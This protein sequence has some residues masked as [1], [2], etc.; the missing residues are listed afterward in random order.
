MV[1]E[2]PGHLEQPGLA[3]GPAVRHRG[4]DQVAGAVQLVAV[5]QMRVP[6]TAG[7]LDPGVE[8]AVRLLGLGQQRGDVTRER[9]HARLGRP[10]H[11]PADRLERLVHV[12]VHEGRAAVARAAHPGP[13]RARLGHGR[14][15]AR[16]RAADGQLQV[17]QVPGGVQLAHGQR[18]AGRPVALLPVGQQA[19]GQ[20]G[21]AA[22]Q[23]AVRHRGGRSGLHRAP[24]RRAQDGRTGN[25]C[26]CGVVTHR[27]T[28][29]PAP[30]GGDRVFG[31][32]PAAVAAAGS[33][34]ERS[35]WS[36]RRVSPMEG[37]GFPQQVRVSR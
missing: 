23:R 25:A 31:G 9:A 11:L 4:L 21:A 13:V 26:C 14:A 32:Q 37:I 19:A 30:R 10:A 20:A 3:G 2:V 35:G 15:R 17:S 16:G 12:G 22:A 8:V 36:V 29:S 33:S 34:V 6:G 5:L 1:G 28:P 24:G 7:D 18:Q 27:L